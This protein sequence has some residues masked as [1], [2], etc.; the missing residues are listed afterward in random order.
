MINEHTVYEVLKKCSLS[1]LKALYRDM[2]KPKQKGV[3][4]FEFVSYHDL[5]QISFFIINKGKM[6]EWLLKAV[7]GTCCYYIASKKTHT[8]L[9]AMK[10]DEWKK[11]NYGYERLFEYSYCVN[12]HVYESAIEYCINYIKKITNIK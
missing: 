8:A 6:Q 1:Q 7:Y 4:G 3:F 9:P 2:K 12:F 10:Y 11:G 5:P